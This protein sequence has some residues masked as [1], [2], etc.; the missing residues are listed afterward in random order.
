MESGSGG[1]GEEEIGVIAL[2]LVVCVSRIAAAASTDRT[3]ARCHVSVFIGAMME[4]DRQKRNIAHLAKVRSTRKRDTKLPPAN[5][6]Q[7]CVGCKGR[8][9][10]V[11]AITQVIVVDLG[12]DS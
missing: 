5:C 10:A 12:G 11:R 3:H 9:C 4:A 7:L 8:S 1:G 6:I 2:L